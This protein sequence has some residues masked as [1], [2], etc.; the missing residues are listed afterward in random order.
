MNAEQLEKALFNIFARDVETKRAISRHSPRIEW[1]TCSVCEVTLPMGEEFD[2]H[3]CCGVG[4]GTHPDCQ[5]C[6][7]DCDINTGRKVGA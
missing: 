4:K 5:R 3:C 2:E 1:D 6:N 7:P